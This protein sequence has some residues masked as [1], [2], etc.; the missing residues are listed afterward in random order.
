MRSSITVTAFGDVPVE[1][2]VD[3]DNETWEC[4]GMAINGYTFEWQNVTVGGIP[5]IEY[6][7]EQIYEELDAIGWAKGAEAAERADARRKET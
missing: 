4:D 7:E 3:Y 2:D 5:F 1:V 6:I